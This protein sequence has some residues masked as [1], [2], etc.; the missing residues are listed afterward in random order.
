MKC[1]SRTP[2]TDGTAR[3]GRREDRGGDD[4]APPVIG[5]SGHAGPARRAMF[6]KQVTLLPLDILERVA[7]VGCVPVLLPPLPGVTDALDRLDGLL[8]PG[9]MDIDPAHYGAGRHPQCRPFAPLRDTAEIAL[10]RAAVRAGVPVLGICRGLQVLNVALGGTLHQY[11]PDLVGHADH[12]PGHDVAGAVE[13]R[14]DPA[15]RVGAALGTGTASVPSSTSRPSTGSAPGSGRPPGPP[16][17]WSRRRKSRTTR[18][19]W[20]AVARRGERRRQPLRG[21]GRRGPAAP[22]P[23]RPGRAC[24]PG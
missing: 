6:D 10:A 15:G 20:R 17:A 4:D 9:G 19:R 12:C 23:G 5:V 8:L 21:A 18:S 3:T 1:P 22:L 11:L 2:W 24:R 7:A 14:L 13:V 16:T